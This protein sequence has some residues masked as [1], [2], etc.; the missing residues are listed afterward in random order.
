MRWRVCYRDGTAFTHLDGEPQDAPGGGVVAVAQEDLNV[1]LQVHRRSDFYVCGEE[2][3]GW[4]GVDI[5]GLVQYL[6]RPGLKII[7]LGEM[8]AP[9][10]WKILEQKILADPN[11]P[12]KSARY[13]WESRV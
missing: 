1:G 9:A 2:Y 6:I 13:P 12:A 3:G 5:Y 10:E 8:M 4:I 7:K 11:L